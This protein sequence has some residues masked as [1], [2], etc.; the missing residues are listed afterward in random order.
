MHEQSRLSLSLS[1]SLFRVG[2]RR[3]RPEHGSKTRR[4]TFLFVVLLARVNPQT[5]GD[6]ECAR[7]QE[8]ERE[9]EKMYVCVRVCVCVLLAAAAAS[10]RLRFSM[11][12][13]GGAYVPHNA[14][15]A[16]HPR[17]LGAQ[18]GAGAGGEREREREREKTFVKVATLAGNFE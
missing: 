6:D 8:R 18:G 1:L 15:P 12:E 14:T 7:A 9:R 13:P 2:V 3:V 10:A 16:R 17:S 4:A 5:S 11:R